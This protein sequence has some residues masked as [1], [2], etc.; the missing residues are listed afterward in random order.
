VSLGLLGSGREH[1]PSSLSQQSATHRLV[2]GTRSSDSSRRFILIGSS[3]FMFIDEEI[4]IT[5]MSGIL[6]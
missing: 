2:V 3:Y 4:I 6:I 5:L 1:R